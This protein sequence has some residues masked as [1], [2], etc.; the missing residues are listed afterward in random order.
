[1][2]GSHGGRQRADRPGR[3]VRVLAIWASLALV[4]FG[5][6]VA[7]GTWQLYRRAWKLDLIAAVHAR[8]D[9]PPVPAP[10]P[11][12][13]GRNADA[14]QR[15]L[16]VRVSGHYLH[17][18][19]TL[20]HGTSRRGYGYWVM[21]PL[22]TERGFTV[23]INRGHVPESLPGTAAFR[24]MPRPRGEVTIT[25]LLRLSKSGGGFLRSNAPDK[26]IWYSRDVKAIASAAG[27]AADRT[28]PYFIDAD[29]R[30]DR[31]GWPVGGLTVIRFPNHHLIYAVTWYA[32][33]LA[34][35]AAAILVVRRER[36]GM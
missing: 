6:F 30:P 32:M 21:T 16:H 10:G 28:A 29:A 2:T 7:L 19:E 8:A 15:Y 22:R 4:L 24:S 14:R 33:G 35:L 25:G 26:G 36:G 12:Q 11:D 9:A 31:D 1:M 17:D 13:W 18:K 27:L 23:L 20:V 34:V 5:G 3:P